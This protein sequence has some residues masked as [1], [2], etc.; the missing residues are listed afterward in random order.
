MKKAKN[1]E[2]IRL[3]EEMERDAEGMQKGFWSRV[4]PKGGDSY[5]C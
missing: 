5:T 4:R 2:W 3:G 1:D